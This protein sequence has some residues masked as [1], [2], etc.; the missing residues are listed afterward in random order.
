MKKT[1]LRHL[2]ELNIAMLCISTSGAL[3][4]F[5]EL[6]PPLTIWWRALLSILFLGGLVILSKASFQIK[7]KKSRAAVVLSGV[8]MTVHWVT[9]FFALQWSNV[10]IGMLSLFTYPVITAFLEPLFL[11]TK[12]QLRHLYLGSL[13]LLGIYFLAPDFDFNNYM[14]LGLMIGLFSAVAYSLRNILLKT[15]I[16][17]V[18]STVLMFYQMVVMVVLLIPVP[19]F[20]DGEG[21][22]EYMPYILLLALVTTS[23]GHTLFLNSFKHFSVSTA[24]LLGGMQPI[25]GILLAVIFLHEIPNGRNMIGGAL[26]ILAVL[27]EGRRVEK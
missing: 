6:P 17:E 24:S 8:L 23:I 13:M 12:F 15:Q 21:V 26:I 11:K 18:N 20:Y 7:I 4:R 2:L 5:I 10:A 9:Y 14:T 1:H 25:Y 19:F 3:G 16:K 22:I 27:L